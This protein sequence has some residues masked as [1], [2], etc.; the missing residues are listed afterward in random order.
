MW[1]KVLKCG[2]ADGSLQPYGAA[3]IVGEWKWRLTRPLNF[4]LCCVKLN[5]NVGH[6]VDGSGE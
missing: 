3:L 6:E 4:F 5:I 2:C 1:N